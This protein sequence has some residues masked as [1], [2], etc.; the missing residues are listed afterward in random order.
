MRAVRAPRRPRTAVEGPDRRLGRRPFEPPRESWRSCG[1]PIPCHPSLAR[2]AHRVPT[3]PRSVLRQAPFG[4][5][6]P[7]AAPHSLAVLEVVATSEIDG[8]GGQLG[9]AIP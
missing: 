8:E 7:P 1:S 9:D 5:A 6:L 4:A 2:G 3:I